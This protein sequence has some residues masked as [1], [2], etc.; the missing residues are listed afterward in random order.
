MSKET[1]ELLIEGG[2]ATASAQLAQSLGPKGIN[3]K[4]VLAKV[5]DKTSN[6]KGMKVPVKIIV[7][8]ETKKFEIE[9]GTPP[10]AE[11]IKNETGASKGASRPQI[12]KIGNLGIEQV[13]KIA[14]MKEDNILHNSFK[15]VVKTVI[16]S[17]NS[18]GILVESL[19]G[20]EINKLID[21]GK[22]DKEINEKKTEIDSEKKER[23]ETELKEI[24]KKN[25]A[26]LERLKEKDKEKPKEAAD[27]A[28]EGKETEKKE[29]APKKDEKKPAKEEKKDVKKE[30][31][32]KEDKKK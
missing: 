16:G 28:G 1:I 23:L 27:E 19:D 26:E 32:K 8:T 6:F 9:I 24:Q 15:A 21:K 25:Q 31:P 11:L 29:A 3:I 5:N 17:C 14:L 4:E 22:F 7:D 18:L 12:E 30:A 10:T 20:K 13:I 2:K